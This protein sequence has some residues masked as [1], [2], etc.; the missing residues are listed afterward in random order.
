MGNQQA[1]A[2]YQWLTGQQGANLG[3]PQS[4]IDQQNARYMLPVNQAMQSYGNL[5]GVLGNYGNA[6]SAVN[7]MGPGSNESG[8][9]FFNPEQFRGPVQPMGNPYQPQPYQ[10]QQPAL[11]QQP[12]PQQQQMMAQPQSGQPYPFTNIPFTGVT[13]TPLGMISGADRGATGLTNEQMYDW[14]RGNAP[15]NYRSPYYDNVDPR[16][17]E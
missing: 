14:A 17:Y 13:A 7:F 16:L 3:R 5:A 15:Q 6:L 9:Q 2:G 8:P 1:L 12:L 11:Q 4:L 10:W